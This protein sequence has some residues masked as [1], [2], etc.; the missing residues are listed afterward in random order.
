MKGFIDNLFKYHGFNS[1]DLDF[2]TLYSLKDFGYYWL[3]VRVQELSDVLENQDK[4]FEICHEIVHVK[5]FHKNASL[6]ILIQKEDKPIQKAEIFKIEE[7]PFQFKKYVL[8]YTK[9]ALEKLDEETDGGDPKA[10]LRKLSDQDVFNSYKKAYDQAVWQKLLYSIAHKLP[11]LKVDV[12]KEESLKSLIDKS[13]MDLEN[14]ELLKFKDKLDLQFES[15]ALRG[16]NKWGIQD[17]LEYLNQDS[18][19]N[20][21]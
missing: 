7:D 21:T 3:V 19:G 8:A 12:D 2:G 16:A 4:W 20:K 1:E 10:L 18:D 15:G 6:L 9:E 14:A 5:D 13:R 17:F 11:F